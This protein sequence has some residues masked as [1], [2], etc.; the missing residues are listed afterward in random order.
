M[1]TNIMILILSV[2]T[3][4][5]FAQ[6]QAQTYINEAQDYLTRKDFKA[7]QMSLQDAINELNNAIA[8]QIV[9]SLP[10]E[11]NGLKATEITTGNQ[12][13]WER[14][15]E[16]IRISKTNKNRPKKKTKPNLKVMPTHL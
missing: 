11:V 14:S 15:G 12:Q 6:G 5:L 1:K 7:A 9:E 8:Q 3:M 4:N 2:F 16:A 13:A 10:A